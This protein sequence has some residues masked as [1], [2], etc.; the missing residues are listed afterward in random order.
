MGVFTRPDSPWFWF[1]LER[2]GQKGVKERSPIRNRP[3]NRAL[4]QVA[5]ET[6]MSEI[7]RG[8]YVHSHVTP[9]K[10]A[11]VPR[12]DTSGWC[13]IYFVSDGELIKIGRAVNVQA[14]L[15]AMQTSASKPLVLLAVLGAH[16]S[17]ER[18]LHRHFKFCRRSRGEWF[19]P[20]PE[21]ISVI[22]AIN[23]GRDPLPELLQHSQA[24]P[25]IFAQLKMA[26]KC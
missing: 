21:L 20:H 5:Y 7:S 9:L 11:P 15:R 2:P 8:I 17:V 24:V 3:E 23:Q 1:W 26:A 13:Y 4:A 6:R 12:V 19:T 25:E 16:I 18:L 10:R 14:R 22:E